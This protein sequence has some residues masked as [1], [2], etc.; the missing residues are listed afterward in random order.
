MGGVVL[1]R[2]LNSAAHLLVG[3]STIVLLLG[4]LGAWW[5]MFDLLNHF[6]AIMIWGALAGLGA[7]IAVRH[8]RLAALGAVL[9]AWMIADLAP[10]YMADATPGGGRLVVEMYNVNRTSGDPARVRAQLEASDADVIG[11]VEPD[12]R[13]FLALAP[14]LQR[15][16]HRL[17]HARDDN[18]G[19]ALY[20]RLPLT[21][22]AVEHPGRFPVIRAEVDG[23][24]LLLVHPP[25]PVS[26]EIAAI[27]DR[28]FAAYA[29]PLQS[30]PPQAIVLGDLNATP[31]S[32]PFRALLAREG[33]RGP[34]SGRGRPRGDLAGRAGSAHRPAHRPCAGARRARGRA[35]R[36]AWRE[37]IGS[38]PDPRGD[39]PAMSR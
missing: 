1:K 25:P 4:L 39:P 7:A 9:L 17:E 22:A 38:P 6:R 31:W 10:L 32:R 12:A 35:L 29:V 23:V 15:W 19:V 13:W 14:A 28:A 16:P 30:L 8:V 26:A 36:G 3:G 37:R 27:R 24:G 21:G 20:S 34:G 11:L 33:R 5:W 2:I 18:F